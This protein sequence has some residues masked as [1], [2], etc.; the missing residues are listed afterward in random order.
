MIL[1]NAQAQTVSVSRLC[2]IYNFALKNSIGHRE[3]NTYKGIIGDSG[4]EI[5][6]F[7][8]VFGDVKPPEH[9]SDDA[10]LFFENMVTEY[11]MK[12]A[13]GL[14][15]LLAA[16]QAWDRAESAR[17]QIDIDGLTIKDKWGQVKNHP[18]LPIERDSRSAFITAMKA[19][20][21]EM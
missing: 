12:D 9:L 20:K 5:C 10:K 3:M 15:I 8:D 6:S 14:K 2:V 16:C 11:G 1:S 4:P 18:L 13:A 19:L 21:I 17:K 7:D